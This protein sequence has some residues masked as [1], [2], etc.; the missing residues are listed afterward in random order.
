ML[1]DNFDLLP[2]ELILLLGSFLPTPSL[3]ALAL[4]CGRHRDTLQS[5]LEARITPAL[6]Q[7]LLLWAAASHPHIVKKLLA[8]PHLLKP[9]EGY[10]A[11]GVTPL[12]VAAQAGNLV[13]A[14][15]LL[16]AGAD[17]DLHSGQEDHPPLHFAVKN[18][19]LPMLTL[20]LDHGA[21]VDA[22]W[23]CDGMSENALHHACAKGELDMVRLLL[24]RGADP[25]RQGHHG[26]ALGF[27]VH[28]R[29]VAVVRLLLDEGGANL[30][31]TVPLFILFRGGPPL[32]HHAD[33]LYLAMG[34]RHPG[35][36]CELREHLERMG[37][38]QDKLLPE[39]LDY[40]WKGQPLADNKREL[41]AMLMAYGASKDATLAVVSKHLS[42]LAKEAEREPDEYLA[43]I[44]GMLKEAEDVI[45]DVLTKY[46]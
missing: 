41:M 46:K 29:Q 31:C 25:E 23:G 34:L 38:E 28:H 22:R 16:A 18:K 3:N 13:T 42:A 17:P 35:A 11:C 26:T 6:A 20:L 19:N 14:A 37:M 36:K 2:T 27:A 39:G 15:L 21:R 1:T 44:K 9:S 8:S 32:P 33:L 10:G 7:Q 24:A 43:I 4:T 45:P 40:T 5:E 30:M 12:H